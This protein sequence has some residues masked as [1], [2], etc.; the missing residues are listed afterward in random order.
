MSSLRRLDLIDVACLVIGPPAH[1]LEPLT[2]SP[3][4]RI[5]AMLIDLSFTQVNEVLK[6]I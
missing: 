5:L 6:Q 1:S 2:F 4:L 3:Q